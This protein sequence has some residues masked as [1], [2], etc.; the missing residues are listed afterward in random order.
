MGWWRDAKFDMFIHWGVYSVPAGV[1]EGKEIKTGSHADKT[2][3]PSWTH[4][5]PPSPR[6]ACLRNWQFFIPFPPAFFPL[7]SFP[8]PLLTTP[9]IP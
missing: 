7:L 4:E 3:S 1:Y 9:F 6:S 8:F 5:E 2:L